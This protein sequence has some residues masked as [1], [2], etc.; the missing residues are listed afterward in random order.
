MGKTSIRKMLIF[1]KHTLNDRSIMLASCV[2]RNSRISQTSPDLS[3]PKARSRWTSIAPLLIVR[4]SRYTTN[5]TLMLFKKNTLTQNWER[6]WVTIPINKSRL[7]LGSIRGNK[8]RFKCG[9]SGWSASIS[10]AFMASDRPAYPNCTILQI[11]INKTKQNMLLKIFRAS[12]RQ[13]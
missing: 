13:N 5:P 2:G 9:W 6:F 8:H 11:N 1:C 12:K 4:W 10:T 7:G 3:L